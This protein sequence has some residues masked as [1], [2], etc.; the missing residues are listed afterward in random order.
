MGV[1]IPVYRY[2][3]IVHQRTVIRYRYNPASTGD[4]GGRGAFSLAVQ[5]GSRRGNPRR[6]PFCL[7]PVVLAASAFLSAGTA[8]QILR[9]PRPLQSSRRAFGK[10][11]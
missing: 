7:T 2:A 11:P 5:K 4:E 8:G 3:P 10:S 1:R 6:E 9:L